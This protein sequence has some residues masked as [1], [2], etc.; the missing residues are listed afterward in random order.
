MQNIVV[1]G[2]GG[3]AKA[4]IDAIEKAGLYHI[5]GLLDGFK[6]AGTFV[7]GYEILG[8]ESWLASNAESI[9]SGIVAV[10]DNWSRSRIAAAIT[11]LNPAFTFITAVHPASSIAKGASIG[12]GTVVMAGAVINSDTRIGDHCVLYPNTSVDHDCTVGSFVTFAPKAATG[13]NVNIGNYSVISLGANIIHG[14]TIGEHTVIGA[15]STVL[16]D[17]GSH[18]IAYGTPARLVRKREP[19]ERYL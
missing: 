11:S 5:V 10:G 9:S 6:T 7:Y 13:G 3:H 12:E 2:A 17:I 14:R 19:G 18:A 1:Y 15:G 4:V 16:S 8:D